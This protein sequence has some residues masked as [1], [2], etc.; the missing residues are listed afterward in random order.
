MILVLMWHIVIRWLFRLSIFY[1]NLPA[2]E[3]KFLI[4]EPD[5]TYQS[6]HKLLVN[7]ELRDFDP[8]KEVLQFLTSYDWKQFFFS[9]CSIG[10]LFDVSQAFK[11]YD[12]HDTGYVDIDTLKSIFVK[13]VLHSTA[14]PRPIEHYCSSVRVFSRIAFKAL[15]CSDVFWIWASVLGHGPGSLG[16]G[17]L[18]ADDVQVTPRR[19]SSVAIHRAAS[20]S[21]ARSQ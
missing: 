5:F 12:P 18:S 7:N 9:T 1:K 11:V 17:D 15:T 3:Y 2:R 21:P 10:D 13:Y 16:F 19:H 20:R 6:L 14:P 8:V 4:G